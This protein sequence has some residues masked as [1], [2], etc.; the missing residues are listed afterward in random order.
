MSTTQKLFI[1]AINWHFCALVSIDEK[2]KS[3]RFFQSIVLLSTDVSINSSVPISVGE[4]SR[5]SLCNWV[6]CK[7]LSSSASSFGGNGENREQINIDKCINQN[8]M[9]WFQMGLR[10]MSCEHSLLHLDELNADAITVWKQIA[11][12]PANVQSTKMKGRCVFSTIFM[13]NCL[14]TKLE[15]FHLPP[16]KTRTCC[17]HVSLLVAWICF[18]VAVVVIHSAFFVY[19][20]FINCAAMCIS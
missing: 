8:P 18:I 7:Q 4:H 10:G 14:P 16:I 13:S 19:L 11:S 5:M 20:S 1:L 6:K 12:A 15:R 17:M 2:R 9:C 3:G